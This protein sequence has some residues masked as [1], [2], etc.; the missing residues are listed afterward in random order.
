M[1]IF[2]P[3]I[4]AEAS[5]ICHHVLRKYYHSPWD[6]FELLSESKNKYN[7]KYISITT[8]ALAIQVDFRSCGYFLNSPQFSCPVLHLSNSLAGPAWPFEAS[9]PATCSY[10]HPSAL[11]TVVTT[12]F[13]KNKS[14]DVTHLLKAL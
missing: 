6:I 7:I 5:I 3:S 12:I 4:N 11:D 1:P 2:S 14:D 8:C 13:S 9:L 10:L